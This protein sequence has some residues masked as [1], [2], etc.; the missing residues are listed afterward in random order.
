MGRE[1]EGGRERIERIAGIRI[2]NEENSK[3]VLGLRTEQS[4]REA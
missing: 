4:A 2:H 3:K 1:K